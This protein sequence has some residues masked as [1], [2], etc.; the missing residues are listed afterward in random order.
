MDVDTAFLN[1]ELTE[2]VYMEI[3]KFFEL[4]N[5]GV[6]PRQHCLRLRKALY[7][8]K[9]AP[10]VWFLTVN[11]FFADIGFRPS[12][13]DPN[14]FIRNGV[15]ILLYV[16]DMLIISKRSEVDQIKVTIKQKWKCKDLG[17]AKLFIGF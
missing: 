7:G 9:Q 4:T 11:A 3:L 17:E 10:R 8:L 5:T 13:S 12:N 15:Y 16:D 14:L 2:E 1:L 6:D